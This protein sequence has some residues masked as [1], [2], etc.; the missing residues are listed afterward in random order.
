MTSLENVHRN[1][2]KHRY[3]MFCALFFILASIATANTAP[4][5]ILNDPWSA[6]L[7]HAADH[8]SWPEQ[9]FDG[10]MGRYEPQVTCETEWPYYTRVR[11]YHGPNDTA[12]VAFR[13]TQ[14]EGW[15]IHTDRQLV[16]CAFLDSGCRGLVLQKFQDAF[17]DLYDLCR[18][19]FEALVNPSAVMMG[20]HSLGGSFNLFLAAKLQHDLGVNVSKAYGFAGPFIGDAEYTQYVQSTL[21]PGVLQFET[22]D[23]QDPDNVFDGTVRFYNTPTAPFISIDE[24]RLESLLIHPL[25]DAYGM[26]DLRN[27]QEAFH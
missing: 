3:T 13:P 20:S 22:R 8:V 17:S 24:G 7:A 11:I 6:D 18:A 25:A 15:L 12:V 26:H 1:L 14:S 19:S 10:L 4:E 5:A 21:P 27:Y 16:P 23:V 9:G 2:L